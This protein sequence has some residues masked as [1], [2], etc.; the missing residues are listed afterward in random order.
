MPF[1]GQKSCRVSLLGSEELFL[2]REV[3]AFEG[4]ST[5]VGEKASLSV[6]LRALLLPLLLPRA[7]QA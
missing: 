1:D 6:C 4:H 2:L 3:R 5:S 7:L